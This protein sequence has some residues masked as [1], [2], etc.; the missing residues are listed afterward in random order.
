[1]A[2]GFGSGVGGFHGGSSNGWH[3]GGGSGGWNGGGSNGWHGGGW[4]N[5]HGGS[6]WGWGGCCSFNFSFGYYGGYPSYGY[7]PYYAYY[8]YPYYAYPYPYSYYPYYPSYPPS[9]G[10][11]PVAPTSGYQV[12]GSYQD[13]GGYV[14]SGEDSGQQSPAEQPRSYVP[15]PTPRS[16]ATTL[17]QA[18]YIPQAS[19]SASAATSH[20]A[21]SPTVKRIAVRPEVDNVVHALRG[22]P[23]A[24]RQRAIA[25]GQ[26]SNLS[27]TEMEYVKYAV[28]PPASIN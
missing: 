13:Q 22:M 16:S 2:G 14:T 4:N 10:Y 3:G 25:S 9:Y 26:Y 18:V 12:Q 5:W 23:P 24:A 17:R 6:G 1:M 27:S 11:A 15:Q 19:N 8:P 7:Y 21:A 28:S 20:Y